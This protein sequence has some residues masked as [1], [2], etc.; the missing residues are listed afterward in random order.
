MISFVVISAYFALREQTY[1]SE[2][3]PGLPTREDSRF[4]RR[5]SELL[6]SRKPPC[7]RSPQGHCLALSPLALWDYDGDGHPQESSL[8]DTLGHA[9]NTSIHCLIITSDMVL[10][11]KDDSEHGIFDT[12]ALIHSFLTYV[13]FTESGMP[14]KRRTSL[15][16]SGG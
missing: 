3:H 8:S 11:G 16:A 7:I 15:L 5:L 9:E 10:A 6:G 13:F 4:E 12:S 2:H 1:V 14:C